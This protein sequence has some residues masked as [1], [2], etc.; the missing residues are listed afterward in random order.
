M[1][2]KK[3]ILNPFAKTLEGEAKTESAFVDKDAMLNC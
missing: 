2:A 1:A 3:F